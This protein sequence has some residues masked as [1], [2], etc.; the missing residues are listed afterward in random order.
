MTTEPAVVAASSGPPLWGWVR[1]RALVV[2]APRTPAVRRR[3]KSIT[4]ATIVAKSAGQRVVGGQP[5]PATLLASS[6]NPRLLASGA[7]GTP[8]GGFRNAARMGFRSSHRR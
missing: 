5:L 3:A 7:R 8:V 1:V 6:G 2:P 4:E